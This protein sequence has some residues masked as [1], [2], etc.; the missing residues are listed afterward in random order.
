MQQRPFDIGSKRYAMNPYHAT[1]P[2][3]ATKILAFFSTA[4]NR[5][6]KHRLKRYIKYTTTK[7]AHA[8]CMH[9]QK[10]KRQTSSSTINPQTRRTDLHAPCLWHACRRRHLAAAARSPRDRTA[11]PKSAPSIRTAR[12]SACAGVPNVQA[13]PVRA[14]NARTRHRRKFK[15]TNAQTLHAKTLHRPHNPHEMQS[16]T[17]RTWKFDREEGKINIAWKTTSP[18]YLF[19]THPSVFR[20]RVGAIFEQSIDVDR[21]AN[22]GRRG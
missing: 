7:N 16:D 10:N 6:F 20:P 3:R 21:I 22:D 17:H 1:V 13:P 2:R 8:N 11:R 9:A 18:F 12:G 14:S 19:S 5:A 4:Q 15:P